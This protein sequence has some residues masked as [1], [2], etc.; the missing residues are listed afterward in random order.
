MGDLKL[1]VGKKYKDAYENIFEVV[2]FCDRKGFPFL[3]V[4]LIEFE[5]DWYTSGGSYSGGKHHGYDLI[6]EYKEEQND[7]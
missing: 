2:Y 3:A 4:D 7:Q 5:A 1:E 6:A